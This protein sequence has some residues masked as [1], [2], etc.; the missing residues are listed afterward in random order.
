[1]FDA[2]LRDAP[3]EELVEHIHLQ[4]ELIQRL[5]RRVLELESSL[6]LLYT[7]THVDTANRMAFLEPSAHEHRAAP[8]LSSGARH[9]APPLARLGSGAPDTHRAEE[10]WCA[11]AREGEGEGRVVAPEPRR[12]APH[13]HRADGAP[14]VSPAP[15]ASSSS[16]TDH[17]TV[18]EGVKEINYVLAAHRDGHP[19]LPPCVV[20]ELEDI[21]MRLLRGFQKTFASGDRDAATPAQEEE[22]RTAARGSHARRGSDGVPEPRIDGR[23]IET[24]TSGDS[25]ETSCT[26]RWVRPRWISPDRPHQL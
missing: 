20:K 25:A 22:G 17:L 12:Q 6:E 5:H 16:A 21:R 2:A 8:S 15:S 13:P 3:R 24:S 18:L 4:R 19:T 11:R 26:S 10:R 1:M 23:R 14:A 9:G 7:D